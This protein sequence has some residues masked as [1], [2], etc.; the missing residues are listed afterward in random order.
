RHA[1]A[2][3]AY[4]RCLV[5]R[6]RWF[7]GVV[8]HLVEDDRVEAGGREGERDEIALDQLPPLGGQILQARAGEAEHLRAPVEADDMLGRGREQPG[9]TAGAGA[10]IEQAAD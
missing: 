1:P 5:E 6:Q 2:R 9:D 3:P 8:E 4:T 10:D 7:G